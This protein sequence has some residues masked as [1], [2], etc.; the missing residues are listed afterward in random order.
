MKNSINKKD[1]DISTMERQHLIAAYKTLQGKYNAEVPRLH[2]EIKSVKI[3]NEQL[4]KQLELFKKNGVNTAAVINENKVAA[5][6]DH[7][8]DIKT[9]KAST[10]NASIEDLLNKATSN[11]ETMKVREGS[12][13]GL[14]IK[15][16]LHQSS[17][18]YDS[19]AEIVSETFKLSETAPTQ[20]AKEVEPALDS[21]VI[22]RKTAEVDTHDLAEHERKGESSEVNADNSKNTAEETLDI[23]EKNTQREKFLTD[24]EEKFMGLNLKTVSSYVDLQHDENFKNFLKQNDGF[25]DQTVADSLEKA[26][27]N[28]NINKVLD[29]C[30]AFFNQKLQLNNLKPINKKIMHTP[31][32]NNH[33]VSIANSQNYSPAEFKKV[34]ESFIK[35]HI[36][37]QQFNGYKQQFDQNAAKN[38]AR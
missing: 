38:S 5:D 2:K 17:E 37:M 31:A 32:T 10:V 18:L 27:E 34:A 16:D 26:I 22:S 11:S 30:Q 8:S 33:S 1:K 19:A 9:S 12:G 36:T 28:L 24:L 15:N 25:S 23:N 35:G 20:P 13:E 29:I 7:K 6:F 21:K 4:L 3:V 14:T